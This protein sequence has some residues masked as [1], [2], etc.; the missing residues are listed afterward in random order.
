MQKVIHM[1]LPHPV[2]SAWVQNPAVPGHRGGLPAEVASPL[3]VAPGPTEDALVG[4]TEALD[5]ATDE[6]V[7]IK[8]CVQ[9]APL[10]RACPAHGA[11]SQPYRVLVYPEGVVKPTAKYGVGM[12]LLACQT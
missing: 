2:F 11:P 6:C 3:L 4:W 12:P 5:K 8:Y 10:R 7:D 9:K 1:C